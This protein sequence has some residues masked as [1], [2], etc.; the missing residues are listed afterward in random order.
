[1]LDLIV[2]AC[3]VWDVPALDPSARE[4][5]VS[6]TPALLLNGN[7]D[8][9]TPPPF[10]AKVAQGFKNSTNVVFP[11]NGHGA[12]GSSCTTE[13]MAAFVNNPK[14][15]PDVSCASEGKVKFITDKNTLIAPGTTWLTKS[16]LDLNLVPL[17]E[18]VLLLAI[19]ILFPVV[20]LAL[21]LLSRFR[22]ALPASVPLGA[23]LSPWLGVLLALLSAAWIGLQLVGLEMTAVI[24]TPNFFLGFYRLNVGIDRSYAWIYMV[25]ILIALAS[26]GMVVMTILAWKNSYWDKRRR[27]YFGFTAGV[28]IA[29]T[30]FLAA[31]GQL[32]VFF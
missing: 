9:I 24:N 19:L 3:Q 11:A 20:W 23:K 14:Q 10:G 29:Y 17:I 31:A 26:V 5:V 6:D 25:P 4:T 7:F 21:W 8:P 32:T 1:M 16:L 13:I 27:L 12:I 18:R 15:R 28:A 22:G 30:L 2:D